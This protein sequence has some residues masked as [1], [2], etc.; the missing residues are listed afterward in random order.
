M[1]RYN[2]S[3]EYGPIEQRSTYIGLMNT[4]LAPVYLFGLAGGWVS[5]LF[6]YETLFSLGILASLAGLALFVFRVRDPRI[7][8]PPDAAMQV[9]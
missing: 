8:P 7:H 9:A 3:V 5:D 2:M 1:V 4:L 6:G